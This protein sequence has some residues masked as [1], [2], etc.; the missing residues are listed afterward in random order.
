MGIKAG[1]II[2]IHEMGQFMFLKKL[3]SKPK[4]LLYLVYFFYSNVIFVCCLGKE[5]KYDSTVKLFHD[6]LVPYF[7]Q[8][9]VIRVFFTFKQKKIK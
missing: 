2:T 7:I 4:Q 5:K 9:L 8:Y 6:K 3:Y 1:N